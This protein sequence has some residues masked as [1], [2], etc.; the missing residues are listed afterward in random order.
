MIVFL[1]KNIKEKFISPSYVGGGGGKGW[2][3]TE[4][5]FLKLEIGGGVE[6]AEIKQ[7]WIF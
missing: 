3:K 2:N 4:V 1:F 5:N 6:R 7:R